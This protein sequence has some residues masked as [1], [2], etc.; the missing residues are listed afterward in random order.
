M[1]AA[2][3]QD[4]ITGG[5]SVRDVLPGVDLDLF[6][7]GMFEESQ[8][9]GI[10]TA[11]VAVVLGRHR[12]YLAIWPR[13]LRGRRVQIATSRVNWLLVPTGFHDMHAK[14]DPRSHRD[15]TRRLPCRQAFWLSA[16]IAIMLLA[17]G[18]SAAADDGMYPSATN[19]AWSDPVDFE[20]PARLPP[21]EMASYDA[22]MQEPPID[23]FPLF[24]G[25]DNGF[26]IASDGSG[27]RLR[28]RLS[29]SHARERVGFSCGTRCST[30][31]ALIRTR[32]RFRLS[33]SG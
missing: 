17:R 11:T 10:T 15:P 27:E 6:A 8:T 28:K 1:F 32:T 5:V 14:E 29:V 30:R 19:A 2:I 33:A 12:N 23:P 25:Y 22:A 26:V 24:I 16:I 20:Q 13:C 21:I 4:R 7:G 31:T 3:P 18:R 9:F